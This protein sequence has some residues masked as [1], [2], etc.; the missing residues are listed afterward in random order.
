MYI[1]LSSNICRSFKINITVR[2]SRY[3]RLVAAYFVRS[4][5]L[6]DN[7]QTN[8]RIGA[9]GMM[10]SASIVCDSPCRFLYSTVQLPEVSSYEQRVTR[11]PISSLPP[12]AFIFS[13]HASHIIPGPLRG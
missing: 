3:L 13:A 1:Q 11:Q 7:P 6:G 9:D 12:R 5:T 4:L 2:K 10:C 8:S